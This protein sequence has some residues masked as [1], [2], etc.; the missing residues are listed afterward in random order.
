MVGNLVDRLLRR[1]VSSSNDHLSDE[2]MAELFCREMPITKRWI[3]RSHLATCQECRIRQEDLE[4]SRAERMLRLYRESIGNMEM[5]LPEKPRAA[6]AQWLELQLRYAAVR[7]E[8]FFPFRIPVRLSVAIPVASIGMAV[9]VGLGIYLFS[10]WRLPNISANSL[11]VHAEKWDTS[12]TASPGVARQTVRIKTPK[13]TMER[14]IY[15]DLNG[16]RRPRHVALPASEE[17]LKSSLGQAGIDWDQPISASAYQDWHDHQ[18]VRTDRISR[19]GSHL[20]T[21]TTTV[22]EGPVSQQSLTVRDTDF[23]PIDR[24]V[25]FR[26][27]ETVEI[28]ELDFKILPWSA[29]DA[30]AFDPIGGVSSAAVPILPHL[31]PSL[32]LPQIPG[33]EQLDET[34]LAARLILNQLHADIDEQIEIH[35][36]PQGIE[37]AGLVETNERKHEL[38]AQLMSVPRLKVSIQSLADLKKN[39][40]SSGE[41]VRVETASLPDQPSALELFLRARGSGVNDVNALAEQLFDGALTISQESKAIVD[42]KTRFVPTEQ[43]P[44]VASATLQELLYSHHERLEQALRK[45]RLLLLTETQNVSRDSDGETSSPGKLSLIEAAARNL[46]LV[47]ELTQTNVPATRN[48]ESIFA[49]MSAAAGDIAAIAHEAYRNPQVN[50]ALNTKK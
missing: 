46:A 10:L 3:A 24:I 9:S 47:K 36:S 22:P 35:R 29:V 42:L 45:Q 2:R 31:V 4:G 43:M 8:R 15:W 13:Q 40:I 5:K 33:P 1:F 23:H 30:N 14:S 50:P 49:D 21:L 18:H 34:E 16:K 38:S 32:H 6:F 27:S 28:A 25:G 39:P 41:A 19:S 20:L 11:L 37:V 17:Q 26:D 7:E 12:S 48:A 44:V